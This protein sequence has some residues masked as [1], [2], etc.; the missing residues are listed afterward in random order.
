MSAV[1]CACVCVCVV[2]SRFSGFPFSPH[3]L[4]VRPKV[5]HFPHFVLVDVQINRLCSN[6]CIDLFLP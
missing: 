4:S 3:K 6:I 5:L 2:V 1:V